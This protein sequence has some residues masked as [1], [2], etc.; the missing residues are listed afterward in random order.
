[1]NPFE[2]LTWIRFCVWSLEFMML[3]PFCFVLIAAA[4]SLTWAGLTQQP[5]R[6]GRWKPYH[7]LVLSHGLF[8]LAAMAVGVFGA[9]PVTNPGIPHLPGSAAGH[10]LDAVIFG[11]I[12]SCVFWI[13]RMKGFRW[14]AASLLFLAEVIT[15]GAFTVA[16]LSV[17]GSWM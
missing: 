8:F 15:W 16:G 3:P 17:S 4:V 14:F 7:S 12:V 9:N 5:F 2:P 1:M 6:A 11:S 13:W 10:C